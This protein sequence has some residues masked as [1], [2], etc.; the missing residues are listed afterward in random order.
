M[1]VFTKEQISEISGQ[2]DCG[3]RAFYH[4]ETGALLFVHNADRYYD[5][6]MTA[7]QED[8][9]ILDENFLDFHAGGNFRVH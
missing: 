2:L 8:L 3:F 4:K 5:M 7:W 6:D 9:D 1:P